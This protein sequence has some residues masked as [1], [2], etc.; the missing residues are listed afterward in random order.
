VSGAIVILGCI[1]IGGEGH[2]IGS[3]LG[4]R[5]RRLRGGGEKGRVGGV[6]GLDGRGRTGEG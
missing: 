1:R 5:G 4:L 3:A 2:S 6:G